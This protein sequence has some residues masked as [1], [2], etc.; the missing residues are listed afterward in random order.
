MLALALLGANAGAPSV[1]ADL[2]LALWRGNPMVRS[3]DAYLWDP[4]AAVGADRCVEVT[5]GENVRCRTRAD[6]HEVRQL[7]PLDLKGLRSGASS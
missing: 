4:L 3:G 1:V 7:Q 5:M 6:A 2:V